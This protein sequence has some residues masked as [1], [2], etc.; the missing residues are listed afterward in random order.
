MKFSYDYLSYDHD[1]DLNGIM[2]VTAL[3]RY[4][5]QTASLQHVHFG[6]QIPDLRREGKAFILC[7]VA[8]DVTGTLRS[9]RPFTVTTWLSN[10]RGY[11]F[12]RYTEF[13]A[14]GITFAKMNAYWGIMDLES[15]HPLRVED[16]P[17]GFEPDSDVLT[18]TSP[19]RYRPSKETVF[20]EL[21]THTVTYGDCDENVHVNNTNYPRI[22]CSLMPTMINKR[23]S[24]FTINY[25]HE[26]R[27]GASFK[28][29]SA[30]EDG[31]KLFRTVL[32]DGNVG[33]EARLVFEDIEK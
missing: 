26:A 32:D 7:R 20:T 15:R 31:A 29:L 14:D 13:T 5:Q 6:P 9:C 22:F 19:L 24:E 8:L 12:T 1:T 21:G 30:D 16:T 2:S 28:V 4:A 33:S 25:L 18:L 3:M 23:V 11:G 27:L 10:A 17:L